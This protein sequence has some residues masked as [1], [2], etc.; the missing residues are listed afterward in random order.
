MIAVTLTEA[1]NMSGVDSNDSEFERDLKFQQWV[2][3]RKYAVVSRDQ[4]V[5]PDTELIIIK[6]T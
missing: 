5:A 6:E 1:M 2:G 4:S 3:S